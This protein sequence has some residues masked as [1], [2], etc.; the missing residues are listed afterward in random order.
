MCQGQK[1][2]HLQSKQPLE[3]LGLALFAAKQYGFDSFHE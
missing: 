1:A 2:A 3:K